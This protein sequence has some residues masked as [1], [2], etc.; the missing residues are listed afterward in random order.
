ME[1]YNLVVIGAGS[2]VLAVAAIAAILGARVALLEKE[3][4]GGDGLNDGCVPSKAL[5]KAAA[6]RSAGLRSCT[7]MT[8]PTPS[9]V[10][11]GREWLC[12]QGL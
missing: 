4:M 10:R 1:R 8:R 11:K 6:A 7:C 5:L 9:T 3:R 2:G 12:I